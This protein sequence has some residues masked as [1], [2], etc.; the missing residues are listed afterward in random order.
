MGKGYFGRLIT[1]FHDALFYPLSL[2]AQKYVEENPV[3]G[4]LPS[5]RFRSER[6]DFALKKCHLG[7]ILRGSTGS[8]YFNIRI[9]GFKDL[10][11]R[12]WSSHDDPYTSSSLG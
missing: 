5:V 12:I 6:C 2:F 3:R 4:C 7:G 10:D 8:P 9:F 11:S 1:V